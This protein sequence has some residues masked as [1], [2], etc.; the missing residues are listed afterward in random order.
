[1]TPAEA[2][3]AADSHYRRG[4]IAEATA[5]ARR[6]LA[7]Q[8][9]DI[10]IHNMLGVLADAVYDLFAAVSSLGRALASDPNDFAIHSN[11]TGILARFGM[12]EPALRS[13]RRAL[14][15]APANPNA[16]N[17][18]A[19]VLK[20]AGYLSDGLARYRRSLALHPD[21]IVHSNLLF[22][23]S[24]DDAIT[25]EEMFAEYRRWD[26]LHAARFTEEARPPWPN[27]ADP[28][29]RLVVGYLSP[30]YRDHPLGRIL[31]SLFEHHDASAVRVAA[32]SSVRGSDAITE[33]CRARAAIWRPVAGLPDDVVARQIRDDGVDILVVFGGHA[34]DNRLLVAARRPAP[35]QVVF[36]EAPTGMEAMDYWITDPVL[37][38]P[39]GVGTTERVQEH[40]LRLPSLFLQ[41]AI[42][43]APPVGEPPVLESGR[44][45]F[46]AFNNPAK[47]SPTALAAWAAALRAVPTSR[48]LFKYIDWYGDPIVQERIVGHFG[49]NGVEHDRLVFLAGDD[50]RHAQLRLWDQVDV[51]L[52]PFP[53]A[54]WT[55]TFEALW[56]GVPVITLV[57]ER[58]AGRIGL[59]VLDH[60]GL[61]DLA[62]GNPDDF[63]AIAA[64]LAADPQRLARL[65]RD[66]RERMRRSPLCD[67]AVQARYFETAYRDIWRRWCTAQAL[68]RS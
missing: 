5:L 35:I 53:F 56:M 61:P 48:L 3:S 15:L 59:T 17:N 49:L 22:V 9:A 8:P 37:H 20:G 21:A 41:P 32:Y 23:M 13:G 30:D 26:R 11:L 4:E 27:A 66:L 60:L 40:L 64:R 12:V 1:M 58:L 38:P 6:A 45:T 54:G 67:G 39:D 46:G 28:D 42:E 25:S 7:L 31:Q 33:A 52:D 51:A 2:L 36:N 57:G 63:G 16:H 62:A 50:D 65:R 24:Y 34:A 68:T 55:S 19:H 29:R 47:L 18:L 10:Q 44:V 14:A 43:D